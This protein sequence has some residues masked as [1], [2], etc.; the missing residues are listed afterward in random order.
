MRSSLKYRVYGL[1]LLTSFLGSLLFTSGNE[2]AS[3]LGFYSV[4]PP[5]QE[6]TENR[7]DPG[8]ELVLAVLTKLIEK[9]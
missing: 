7:R 2:V 4:L 3:F 9:R 1:F 8:N 6:E 5:E